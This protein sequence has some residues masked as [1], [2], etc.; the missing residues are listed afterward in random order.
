MVRKCG[1]VQ[2]GNLASRKVGRR[3]N[4]FEHS[5]VQHQGVRAPWIPREAYRK[6]GGGNRRAAEGHA[7]RRIKSPQQSR[8]PQAWI[9][10]NAQ[11]YDKNRASV[12]SRII[13]LRKT[14]VQFDTHG[15]WFKKTVA[16]GLRGNLLGDYPGTRKGPGTGGLSTS[17]ML[18]RALPVGSMT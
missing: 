8:P 5:T 15:P 3:S 6:R 1:R 12:S 9:G 16:P 18:G 11:F 4:P 13:L 2:Q 17:N 10:A 7:C 14:R